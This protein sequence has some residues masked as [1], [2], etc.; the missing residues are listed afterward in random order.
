MSE[1]SSQL[2]MSSAST[3]L[4]W[5]KITFSRWASLSGD[6]LEPSTEISIIVLLLTVETWHFIRWRLFGICSPNVVKSFKSSSHVAQGV[7]WHGDN[8]SYYH[9]IPCIFNIVWK[10]CLEL[11][12]LLYTWPTKMMLLLESLPLTAMDH[13]TQESSCT[14][15]SFN[16][17][18][19]EMNAGYYLYVMN[20]PSPFLTDSLSISLSLSLSLFRDFFGNLPVGMAENH[21][22]ACKIIRTSIRSDCL[23]TTVKFYSL[24]Q[25]KW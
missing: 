14:L 17:R 18:K 3:N 1:I 12:Y 23:M 8:R 24:D 21:H 19:G 15:K 6:M 2:H 16:D 4:H 13:D 22:E 25:E 11:R 5:T 9:Y 7:S 10:G 20:A